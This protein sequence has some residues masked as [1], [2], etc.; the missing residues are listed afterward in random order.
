M[1]NWQGQQVFDADLALER[2]VLDRTTLH[3]TCWPSRG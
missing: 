3:R 2:R 1:E